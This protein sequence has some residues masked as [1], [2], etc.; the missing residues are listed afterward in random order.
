MKK[1]IKERLAS[2][3]EVSDERTGDK[4]ADTPSYDNLRQALEND[5]INHAE[6]M[7]RLWPDIDEDTGRSEFRKKLLQ[8]N[9]DS[10]G[11]YSFSEDEVGKVESI[12]LTMAKDTGTKIGKGK[13]TKE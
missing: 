6:V 1:L 11:K 2:L 9:N 7:R 13:K 12:L 3:I 8:K 10:G 4:T 5:L